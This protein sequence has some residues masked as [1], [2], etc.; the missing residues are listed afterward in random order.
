MP[1]TDF[2][3]G[4]SWAGLS[5]LSILSPEPTP[6]I[7]PY[8]PNILTNALGSLEAS[9][10]PSGGRF[11]YDYPWED[12]EFDP[13]SFDDPTQR[14]VPG[15]ILPG[16]G[17][18]EIPRIGG[19]YSLP[20][21]LPGWI[22]PYPT[23][24]GG[25]GDGNGGG[26]GGGNGGGGGDGG[27][28]GWGGWGDWFDKP[29]GG[30]IDRLFEFKPWLKLPGYEPYGPGFPG[31]TGVSYSPYQGTYP[32][33]DPYTGALLSQGEDVIGQMLRGEGVGIPYESE[34]YQR[35]MG[36]ITEAERMGQEELTRQAARGGRIES[37]LY[38]AEQTGL[39]ETAMKERGRV[40]QEFAVKTAEMQQAAREAGVPMALG[41]GQFGAQQAQMQQESQERAWQAYNMEYTKVYEAAR[42]RGLDEYEAEKEAHQA[43]LGEYRTTYESAILQAK[44]LYDWVMQQGTWA[45]QRS[46][47]RLGQPAPAGIGDYFS[48][49]LAGFLSNLPAAIL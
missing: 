37:G 23:D 7:D 5:P 25:D 29:D 22:F 48:L 36:R 3:S 43:G 1:I 16:L 19:G 45:Q 32:T 26:D 8:Q 40:A 4:S 38:G 2:F 10:P 49:A 28:D 44:Q 6:T 35:A 33:Y 18:L 14:G 17:G 47:A 15:Q 41:Y 21:T 20:E 27:W 24:D 34:Q 30:P 46:L 11:V 13:P 39:T 42:A 9:A 31:Y 12:P